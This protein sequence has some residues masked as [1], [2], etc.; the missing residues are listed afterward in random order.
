MNSSFNSTD[1]ICFL[2]VAS[3]RFTVVS[4]HLSVVFDYLIV[5]SFHLTVCLR[6]LTIVHASQTAVPTSESFGR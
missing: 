3:D 5:V 2:I 6:Y 4:F 1:V